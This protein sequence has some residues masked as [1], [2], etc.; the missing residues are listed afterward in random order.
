MAS[1]VAAF[2]MLGMGLTAAAT[3]ADAFVDAFVDSYE[4]MYGGG[5]V[6]L[7]NTVYGDSYLY[8]DGGLWDGEF[9]TNF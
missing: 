7:A 6:G 9:V 5:Y 1:A 2:A 4:C 3:H 8:C